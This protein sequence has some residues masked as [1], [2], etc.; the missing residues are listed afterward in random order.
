MSPEEHVSSVIAAKAGE[1]CALAELDCHRV[2]VAL[3]EVLVAIALAY[4]HDNVVVRFD[5]MVRD[6]QRRAR[7]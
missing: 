4:P 7:R 1:L 3:A 2:M 6:A 5:Q